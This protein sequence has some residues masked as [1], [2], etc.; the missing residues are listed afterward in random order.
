MNV[1]PLPSVS[2]LGR[3]IDPLLV[4]SV[5]GAEGYASHRYL[6]VLA[7]AYSGVIDAELSA[8][9][10]RQVT[11]AAELGMGDGSTPVLQ[12]WRAQDPKWRQTIHIESS[13]EYVSR[14]FDP[15]IFP[16]VPVQDGASLIYSVRRGRDPIGSVYQT[17]DGAIDLLLTGWPS[18]VLVDHAPGERRAEDIERIR[19]Q[20]SIIVVHDTEPNGC[21][22]YG[23]E[24]V[25]SKFKYRLNDWPNGGRTA[26]TSIVSDIVDV[27][28]PD[29]ARALADL[30]AIG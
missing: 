8:I 6:L 19:W 20:S 29:W 27:S 23:Y 26:G 30:R 5:R 17:W 7:L 10:R 4:A 13:A 25:L 15:S 2:F 11:I 24:P 3:E 12:A 22:N 28:S 14:Y 21:G 1:S 9:D 16:K 18:V